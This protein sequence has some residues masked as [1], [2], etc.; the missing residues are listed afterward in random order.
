MG[1]WGRDLLLVVVALAVATPYVIPALGVRGEQLFVYPIFAALLVGSRMTRQEWRIT[2]AF[3]IAWGSLIPI[4]LLGSLYMIFQPDYQLSWTSVIAS[5]DSILLGV[6]VAW[7]AAAIVIKSREPSQTFRKLAMAVVVLTASNGIVSIASTFT[8]TTPWLTSFWSPNAPGSTSVAVRA[9]AGDRYSG[10][11][12]QPF[13]AGLAHSVGLLLWCYLFVRKEVRTFW[14]ML[15]VGP[16]LVGGFLPVS[17]VFMLGGFPLALGFLVWNFRSSFGRTILMSTGAGA[18]SVVVFSFLSDIT[19]P[20]DRLFYLFEEDVYGRIGG[21][22]YRVGGE[23]GLDYLFARLNESPI[24]GFGLDP[25]IGP[26]DNAVLAQAIIGGV[27]GLVALGVVVWMLANGVAKGFRA[28]A[29]AAAV[30]NATLFALFM[31]SMLGAHPLLVNRSG[32]LL[33]LVLGGLRGLLLR[34]PRTAGPND[35]ISPA[36]PTFSQG[37]PSQSPS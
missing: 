22:R 25:Q 23:G 11:F 20:G 29:P 18:V 12:N 2:S 3:P 13:E 8:D 24:I 10:I 26:F 36:V 30:A 4:G 33:L 31:A 28:K 17:K 32:S 6:A 1:V 19:R 14:L 7:I 37:A 5:V 15:L 16:L 34:P 27:V 35:R 21:D 9:L